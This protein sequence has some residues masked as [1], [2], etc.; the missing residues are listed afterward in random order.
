MEMM[1]KQPIQ[2][3]KK[4]KIFVILQ[5]GMPRPCVAYLIGPIRFTYYKTCLIVWEILGS[6]RLI[7][8][9][10]GSHSIVNKVKF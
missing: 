4:G 10:S 5:F 8:G 6:T 3:G 1:T 9:A 2:Q 7:H